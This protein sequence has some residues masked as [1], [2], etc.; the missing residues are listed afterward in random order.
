MQRGT[1]LGHDGAG[2]VGGQD[3]G[4]LQPHV[5]AR[6]T[7]LCALDDQ[8]AC[9]LDAASRLFQTSR[10]NP[11]GRFDVSVKG[12]TRCGFVST[13]NIPWAF[14]RGRVER[15]GG[16]NEPKWRRVIREL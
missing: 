12:S 1:H 14:W 4:S 2:L 13:G 11:P 15:G 8:I 7:E 5:L 3:A 6:G 16:I 10:S 9:N